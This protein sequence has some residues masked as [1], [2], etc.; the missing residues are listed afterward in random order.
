MIRV[1]GWAREQDRPLERGAQTVASS[2]VGAYPAILAWAAAFL[3]L[4]VRR[5]PTLLRAEFWADDGTHYSEALAGGL[6]TILIT[7]GGSLL[8]V[9]R[10]IVQVAALLPPYWAPVFAN[11]VALAL[12]AAVA[13]FMATRLPYPA[14]TRF[15]IA[16]AFLLLPGS[17]QIM[18]TLSHLQWV[19]AAWLLAMTVAT[20]SR[21]WSPALALAGLTGPQGIL[22]LPLFVAA[23]IRDRS[24]VWLAIA[25]GIGAGIQFVVV[26]T[27]GRLPATPVDWSLVPQ[28]L[29][30]RTTYLG[31]PAGLG[32]LA[33]V[34]FALRERPMF[35]FAIAYA[36]LVVPL[37]GILRTEMPTEAFLE[38]HG[39]R[40]FWLATGLLLV[41]CLL[42]FRRLSAKLAL[43]ALGV[44]VVAGFLLQP[45][46]F[47]NW[48]ENSA[49]IGGS[50]PCRVPVEPAPVYDVIWPG[51]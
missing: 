30:E 10:A 40:Y 44:V 33:A 31:L 47:T 25:L 28:I 45:V 23:A 29:V 15:A 32:V 50:Q 18:G 8:I 19:I 22:L 49:C 35:G 4:V 39:P 43:T 27:A 9:Q 37:A 14:S 38:G 7:Y 1:A 46:P 17:T 34:A 24:R 13:V 48:A 21:R 16:A 20:V 26:L 42:E 6:Q 3:V 41:V 11:T 51:Q 12:T 2:A 5:P 36:V